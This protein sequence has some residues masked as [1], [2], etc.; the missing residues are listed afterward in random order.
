[1]RQSRLVAGA[2]LPP[3]ADFAQAR[4]DNGVYS[5][6]LFFFN[7]DAR[8]RGYAHACADAPRSGKKGSGPVA[9][10]KRARPAAATDEAD[11]A[12][13]AESEA[14]GLDHCFD[15]AAEVAVLRALV[16]QVW[17]R[18][19]AGG[20]KSEV[21]LA[22][23]IRRIVGC[24]S[25]AISPRSGRTLTTT[26]S[27]AVFQYPCHVSSS[28]EKRWWT[29]KLWN[30]PL[31]SLAQLLDAKLKTRSTLPRRE[32]EAAFKDLHAGDPREA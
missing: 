1:M 2:P 23:A 6:Q 29:F 19:V 18:L 21:A 10:R 4:W 17:P 25:A 9:G 16:L 28:W 22:C 32:L 13:G 14:L 31:P 5:E 26:V 15:C 7:T 11:A 3:L 27:P 20:A 8:V 30:T 24:V 12:V